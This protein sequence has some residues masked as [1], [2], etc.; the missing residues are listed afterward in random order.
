MC[1]GAT[2]S[3][4]ISNMEIY[5]AEDKKLDQT[6]M[7][8]LDKNIC[9]GYHLYMDNYYNSIR[10]AELLMKNGTRVCG[11]I[12]ANRSVP[13]S[14]KLSKLKTGEYAFKRK[15]EILVQAWKPKKNRIH[16]FDNTFGTINKNE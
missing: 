14:F 8:L 13:E 11:T 4:Y 2:R 16:G 6:I 10:T 9:L 1:L 15:G 5:T 7:S 3:G 12:R